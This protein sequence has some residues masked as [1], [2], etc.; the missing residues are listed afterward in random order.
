MPLPTL[1]ELLKLANACRKA[2]IVTF[3]G[4]GVEFTLADRP[5]KGKKNKPVS[6][7]AAVVSEGD[8]DNLSE[9]DKLMWSSATL[10]EV[11]ATQES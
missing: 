8:W 2:G 11:S 9:M 10:P 6:S 3:K 7:N 1:K 5:T 4:E